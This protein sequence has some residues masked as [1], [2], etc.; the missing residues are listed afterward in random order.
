LE[1]PN[2]AKVCENV[3]TRAYSIVKVQRVLTEALQ[4]IPE[5][6]FLTIQE[7]AQRLK[8]SPRSIY[9]LVCSDQLNTQRVGSGRGSI[10]IAPADI[11]NI[12]PT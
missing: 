6:D 7:A 5:D 9:D 11:S 4:A 8:I 3:T 10:R 12:G 2:V 1:L